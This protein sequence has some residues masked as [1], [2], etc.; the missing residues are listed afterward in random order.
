MDIPPSKQVNKT[1][2]IIRVVGCIVRNDDRLLMLHRSESETDPSL[3]GI[4]AGKAEKGETDKQTAVREIFEET[5]LRLKEGELHPLGEIH[6]VYETF[7]VD[8]PVF[9]V[10]FEQ[11]PEITLDPS[12]H[13]AYDWLTAQEVLELPN[14]MKDVDV[15]I[16]K[17]CSKEIGTVE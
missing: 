14:L 12:E 2:K 17:F 13:V 4:P 16:K 10:R 1:K 11:R 6:I 7:A 9:E 15:I 5:G 8:F 3:W